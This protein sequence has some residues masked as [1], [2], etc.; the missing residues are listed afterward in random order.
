M[1]ETV[2]FG[3]QLIFMILGGNITMTIIGITHIQIGACLFNSCEL[4]KSVY[5]YQ[6]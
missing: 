2:L 1:A 3:M 4:S 6:M 5:I